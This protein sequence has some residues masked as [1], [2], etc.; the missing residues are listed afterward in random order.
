MEASDPILLKII[1]AHPHLSETDYRAMESW[2]LMDR[3][4]GESAVDFMVRQGVFVQDATRTIEMLR[5][6]MLTYWDPKR[7]FGEQG[8]HRLHEYANQSGFYD[9]KSDPNRSAQ[10]DPPSMPP[11]SSIN[12]LNE[13]REWLARRA[14]AKQAGVI[15]P[16]VASDVIDP[17]SVPVHAA[18]AAP[19]NPPSPRRSGASPTSP[20]P[21]IGEQT[22]QP[23]ADAVKKFPQVGDLL[24]KYFLAEEVA[25]GGTAVVFRALNRS[26]NSIVAIKVLKIDR[27]EV[28]SDDQAISLDSLRRE[29]Q[30]LARFNHPNLV[31]VFDLEEDLAFP[32]LVLEFVDGLSLSEMLVH[33][34]R[35][36]IDRALNI[37]LAVAEGLCAAQ[38]KIGLVHRDVKPGNVL[39]SRDGSVKLADLGLA[40]VADT[41]QSNTNNGPNS[42]VLAGTAAYMA[43]E[44]CTGGEVDHR[45][46]I[47]SLGATFYHALVGQMPFRG[48][49]RIEVMLKHTKEMPVPPHQLVSGLDPNLSDFIF[50]MMAK[51]PEERFQTYDELLDELNQVYKRSNSEMQIQVP[52]STQINTAITT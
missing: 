30:M 39:L 12:K 35:L 6:G 29:A 25:R 19:R 36:R 50:K 31:R 5:K 16:S 20:L 37:V 33:A 38:R 28:F 4:P 15:R 23:F 24:G 45:S 8:H 17:P 32:F 46:D 13:V 1:A 47:Y 44:Q 40:M 22:S 21:P 48:K 26:L 49:N 10:S 18:P 42:T 41:W 34:G 7:I 11:A 3:R 52:P 27:E 51:N 43:P 9:P 14:E 2:W